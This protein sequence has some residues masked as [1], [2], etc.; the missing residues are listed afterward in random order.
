VFKNPLKKSTSGFTRKNAEG[1]FSKALRQEFS[2]LLFD[3]GIVTMLTFYRSVKALDAVPTDEDGDSLLFQWGTYSA[4]GSESVFEAEITRQV[5]YPDGEDQ[6]MWQLHFIFS[7]PLTAQLEELDEG[8]RWCFDHEGL[9]EFEEWI[10]SG[11][12]FRACSRV[13]PTSVELLWEQV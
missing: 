5:I 11:S 13:Q 4:K 2:E 8:H 3:E 1:V 10:K 6:D 7:F 9:D 12:V